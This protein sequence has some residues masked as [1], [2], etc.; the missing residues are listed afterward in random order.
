METD[1]S[2]LTL[3]DGYL[4]VIYCPSFDFIPNVTNYKIVENKSNLHVNS[5][6]KMKQNANVKL[7]D[8]LPALAARI[9]TA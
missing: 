9:D 2:Y 4:S 5:L 1:N 7:C 8:G 3:Y 6:V